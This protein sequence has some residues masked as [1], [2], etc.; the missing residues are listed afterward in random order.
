MDLK[1]LII[2]GD[3]TAVSL[4]N[5]LESVEEVKVVGVCDINKNSEAMRYARQLKIDTVIDL[6]KFIN[7]KEVNIIIETTGREEFQ[8][9]LGQVSP[10]EVTV[11][12]SG[13][14]QF[15]EAIVRYKEKE[16]DKIK[17]EFISTASHELRTPLAAIKEAVMLMI[18]GET[19][20]VSSEQRRFLEIANRNVD[21]LTGLISDLLDFSKIDTGKIQLKRDKCDMKDVIQ[22]T[23][24][25]LNALAVEN[26]IIL[27]HKIAAGLPKI[28]CDF[29]KVSRII[30]NLVSNS[31]KFTPVGG[32]ITVTCRMQTRLLKK[33]IMRQRRGRDCCN[34]REGNRKFIE[35]SVKDTGEGIAEK[36]FSRLFTRF[37]Q[38]DASL[39][40]R[41]GGTGLGLVICKELVQMH[42]GEIWVES[43]IGKG[44]VFTFTLPSNK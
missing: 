16:I 1:V 43:K 21:R 28:M 31:I 3:Q 37:G 32:R 38:L 44:S 42:G 5:I 24:E 8:K 22:K 13:I 9:V 14:A 20:P 39:T 2:G 4:I 15:L 33:R 19:G 18:D 41:P 29:E 30:T 34:T 17:S 7:R 40:R 27:T 26:K 11:I 25:P 35:I 6:A 10:R 36:D 12:A 23:L